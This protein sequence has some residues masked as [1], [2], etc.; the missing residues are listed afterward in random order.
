MHLPKSLTTVTIFSK[1]FAIALFIVLPIAGLYLVKQYQLQNAPSDK[2]PNTLTPSVEDDQYTKDCYTYTIYP[3]PDRPSQKDKSK[4]G[5]YLHSTNKEPTC[6]KDVINS[7]TVRSENNFTVTLTDS[8]SSGNCN[9]TY[10]GSGP[11][12]P[13]A[14]VLLGKL[15]AGTYTVDII[16]GRY[17]IY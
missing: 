9:L 5:L 14:R 17:P 13:N 4:V 12:V 10:E 15:E 3:F 16:S 6:E 8:T 2:L 7:T 1:L 11:I